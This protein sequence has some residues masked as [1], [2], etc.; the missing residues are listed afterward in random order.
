VGVVFADIFISL[1]NPNTSAYAQAPGANNP[2]V[3]LQEQIRDANQLTPTFDPSDENSE[4]KTES[5]NNSEKD[6]LE[7]DEPTFFFKAIRFQGNTIYDDQFLIE[8]FLNFIGK[9]ITFEQLKLAA[10]Q[11]ESIYKNAGYIT[12]RVLIPKQ[13]IDSGNVL[14]KVVEGY[15][16]SVEV[17]G[18]THGV[19]AYARKMLQPVANENSGTIFN[20]KTLQ[21][22][23]LLVRDF[24]ATKFSINLAK[25][26]NL[27]GSKLIV[28][29]DN[30]YL[31]G[32]IGFNNFV[33]DQMGDFQ[34]TGYGQFITPTSQPLKITAGGSY[35]YPFNNYGMSTGYS[36]LSSPIGNQGFVADAL[37]STSST[38][39]KDL[40]PRAN[41]K[42]QSI[43]S[44]NFWQ[45]GIAYPIVLERNSKLSIAFLGSG[46]N[47]YSDLYLDNNFTTNLSTDKIR[48]A[49]FAVE[50]YFAELRSVNTINFRL[51]QGIGNLDSDLDSDQYLS[52]PLSSSTFTKARLDLKRTQKVFDFGTQLTI[53]G[54]GQLSS[55]SLPSSESFTYGGPLYGKAF[56]SVYL[57]GDQGWATAIELGQKINLS[58]F[59][60][61][62]ELIPYVWYDY[63]NTQYKAGLLANQ[64]ASTYGIGLRGNALNIN[65]ELW[66]GI[67]ASNSLNS[68]FVGTSN[69]SLG[70]NTFWRF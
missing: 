68:E 5:V 56:R 42:F 14:I 32:M 60:Q 37:W 25:G 57:L 66:W 45:F 8:P 6:G 64:T 70:F 55:T 3:Q 39:T 52:N 38:K 46:Q 65:Y 69:S 11:S 24:G 15:I 35:S 23:L 54:S 34:I 18:A 4:V 26:S 31:G 40:F 62:V 28:D 2:G 67:P 29:L 59:N 48:T 10:L 30:N 27:G 44:S 7:I 21:R 9:S 51:S 50:G 49:Q 53:K 43:G 20:Y 41:G 12:T 16:E 61:P 47:T 1:V 58:A 22:Q 13:D 63:G 36:L 33:S 17:R 19:Q